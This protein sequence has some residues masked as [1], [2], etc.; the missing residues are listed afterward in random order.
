[1]GGIIFGLIVLV[2]GGLFALAEDHKTSKMSD[3]ERWEY[4][5]KKAKKGR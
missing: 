3:Q 2:I 1:M 5:W 4:E